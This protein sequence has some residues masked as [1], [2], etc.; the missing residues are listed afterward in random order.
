MLNR[1]RRQIAIR[2]LMID[3]V[4]V[5]NPIKVKEGFHNCFQ[6]L[7]QKNSSWRPVTDDALFSNL[8]QTQ[9]DYLQS[10][11]SREEIKRAVWDCGSNKSPSPD[12][13]A[14]GFFLKDIGTLLL[15]MLRLLCT[16]FSIILS[17][18]RDVML[19]FSL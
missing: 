14:F 16:T 3:G 1:K 2:G 7:F 15:L 5:D 10:P 18:P 8:S 6:S 4:W 11:F 19:R 13:F 9:V 12:G 17:Y